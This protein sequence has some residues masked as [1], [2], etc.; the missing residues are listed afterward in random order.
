LQLPE[1]LKRLTSASLSQEPKVLLRTLTQPEADCLLLTVHVE[2]G[3]VDADKQKLLEQVRAKAQRL[4]SNEYAQVMLGEAEARY[5]D[6]A[7]AH[8]DKGPNQ[9]A[10]DALAQAYTSLP[11]YQPLALA[12]ARQDLHDG[13]PER[14][15]AELKPFAYSPHG[16]KYAQ[17]M[18]A[19]IEEI[20]AKKAPVLAETSAEEP[21]DDG[22]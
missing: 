2:L 7:R 3:V 14:A 13:K 11:Q 19:W 17:K 8:E 20:E 12:Q 15:V 22:K 4:G 1:L 6:A 21:S 5:A 18:R 16:E 10:I 9:N